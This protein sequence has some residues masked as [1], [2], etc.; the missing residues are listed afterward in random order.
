[1]PRE[2]K[3]FTDGASSGNP[4]PGG[5]G[6]IVAS[7]SKVKE[8]GGG[9]DKTTNNRMELKAVIEALK[10]V[11]EVNSDHK[12][13][14]YSDSSYVIN[15]S[16][17]WLKGWKRNNWQTKQK[18]EVLNKDLWMEIDP[19][20]E[21]IDCSFISVEGHVG[22]PANE[23]ADKIATSFSQDENIELFDGDL[24]DYEVNLEDLG[25]DSELKETKNRSKMKAYS[26]LS[27]V[28]GVLEKHKTWG[29]CEDR[30]KGKSDAKFRKAISEEDEKAILEE[31]GIKEEN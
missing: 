4:G 25:S 21:K 2:I 5:W 31:W 29:D 16:T 24:S 14:I 17:S 3:I 15:G 18:S 30:V 9:E 10:V 23:R 6:A 13:T 28:D 27:L 22:I 11:N 12:V 1:M 8:I 7:H 19:L 26:Y 20:L